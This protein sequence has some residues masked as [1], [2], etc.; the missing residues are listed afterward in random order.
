MRKICI[1]LDFS[2]VLCVFLHVFL[3]F[4]VAY[5]II[6][7]IFASDLC[8]MHQIVQF[9]VINRNY[10]IVMNMENVK[11]TVERGIYIRPE[12]GYVT[13]EEACMAFQSWQPHDSEDTLQV[14][15]EGADGVTIPDDPKGAKAYNAWDIELPDNDA[16]FHVRFNSEY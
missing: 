9:G 1:F 10:D 15:N 16:D 4:F 8:I 2:Q 14:V 7:T 12:I 5:L 11:I 3:P 13:L 6:F